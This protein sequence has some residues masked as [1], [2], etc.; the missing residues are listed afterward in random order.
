MEKLR[1]NIDMFNKY[2]FGIELEF[3]NIRLND[4]YE[5]LNRKNIDLIYIR[6]KSKN[7]DYDTWILGTDSTVTRNYKNDFIGGELSSKIMTDNIDDWKT[8]KKICE[9]LRECH[10]RLD[11]FCSNQITINIANLKN[12][13]FFLEVLCKLIA[14]YEKEIEMF[15]MGDKYF[16]RK[17]KKLFARSIQEKL[18]EKVDK[19]DFN[20]Y[21]MFNRDKKHI[22]DILYVHPYVFLW[23]DG[24]SLDKMYLKHLI[25]IRYPNGT[26]CE[27]TVQNNVNFSIKLIDAINENKFDIKYLDYRINDEKKE[28]DKNKKIVFDEDKFY[29]LIEIISTSEDDKIDFDRQ[30]QKVL[31]TK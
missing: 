25:E 16:D 15:Y 3:T 31:K 19:I 1:E 7:E 20:K 23:N 30:F 29:E 6:R 5:I 18:L 2:E 14:V 12:N 9:A 27:K 4:L 11:D 24:I 8:L 10:V 13:K 26:L 28:M 21:Y 17:A 22:E